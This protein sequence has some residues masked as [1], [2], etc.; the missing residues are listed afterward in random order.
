VA[1]LVLKTEKSLLYLSLVGQKFWEKIAQFF[2][3]VA[4]KV[5]LLKKCQNLFNNT[6]IE[7]RIYIKPLV[8]P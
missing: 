1:N 8:K 5:P 2:K 7:S 3:K 4:Q 6:Q